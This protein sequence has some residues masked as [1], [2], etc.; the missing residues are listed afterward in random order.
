LRSISSCSPAPDEVIV[1]DQST[2]GRARAAISQSEG[3]LQ[4]R[5][6]PCAHEGLAAAHNAGIAAA[7]H[8]IVLVTHDDCTVAA[9]WVG[10][11]CAEL[12]GSPDAIVTGQVFPTGDYVRVPTSRVDPTPRDYYVEAAIDAVF[13]NNMAF[14]RAAWVS[15]GGLDEQFHSA[16]EDLDLCYRWLR[17]GRRVRYA[18]GLQV[19]HHDWRTDSQVER[20]YRRYGFGTGQFYGKHL[21][22]GDLI[23]LRF[24]VKD[25]RP[26]WATVAATIRRPG[27]STWAGRGMGRRV[28]PG[29]IYGWSMESSS[30]RGLNATTSSSEQPST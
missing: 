5:H 15:F 10:V 18:P 19:F 7:S 26:F 9:D 17:S 12:A 6:L 22:H 3:L 8:E 2:D 29:L 20:M 1:V 11:A 4:T 21:R 14:H 13:S 27:V 25:L 16:G 23:M 28:W 30:R 24:L